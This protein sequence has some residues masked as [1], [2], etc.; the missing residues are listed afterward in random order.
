MN[1]NDRE[2]YK[3]GKEF[4]LRNNYDIALQHLLIFEEGNKDY[5]DVYNMLGVIFHLN[6]KIKDA[7]KYFESA[8]RINPGYMEAATNLAV[9][10][11]DI[12]QYE[13]AKN[14]LNRAKESSHSGSIKEMEDRLVTSKLSNM[15]AEIGDL[16]MEIN[17]GDAAIEEYE[18]AL[19]L[20]PTF[21]DIKT[22]LA[23]A[24]REKGMIAQAIKELEEAKFI[25]ADYLP[26]RVNLGIVYYLMS[27]LDDAV[28]EWESVLKHDPNNG[29]ARMYLNAARKE[30]QKKP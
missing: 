2:H 9:T 30:K 15:H 25:N 8:M 1:S 24:F 16:Y 6:G 10:Y 18:K 21:V 23:V 12:G 17:D 20:Q 29:I 5:A 27:R 7:I 4:F 22:K 26:A 3:L 11:N 28:V 14:V 19:K 13:K